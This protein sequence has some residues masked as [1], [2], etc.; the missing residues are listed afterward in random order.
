MT[1]VVVNEIIV[2]LFQGKL[3]RSGRKGSTSS[4]QNPSAVYAS[5]SDDMMDDDDGGFLRRGG[6]LRS[7]LPVVRSPNKSTE[8]PLGEWELN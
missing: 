3:G 5:D 8:K 6:R 1:N 4:E 7:S 2:F